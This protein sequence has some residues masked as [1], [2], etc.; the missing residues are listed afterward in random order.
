MACT[1]GVRQVC[2]AHPVYFVHLV[3]LVEPN[4]R[5]KLNKPNNGFFLLAAPV[6]NIEEWGAAAEAEAQWRH[7]FETFEISVIIH[8]PNQ[9]KYRVSP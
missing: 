3:G 9:R 6:C 5:D 1:P 8:G 4:K 7:P 2:L